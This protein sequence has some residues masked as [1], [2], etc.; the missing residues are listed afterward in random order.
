VPR[1]IAVLVV[2]ASSS[3][4]AAIIVDSHASGLMKRLVGAGAAEDPRTRAIRDAVPTMGLTFILLATSVIGVRCGISVAE[5]KR[6]NT[7][8]DLLLTAQSFR[9]ITNGKMWGILHATFPYVIAYTLPVFVVATVGGPIAL[10]SAAVWL[11]LP[12]IA[13]LLAA[14]SGIDMLRIPPDMDETRR[15]GAFWFENKQTSTYVDGWGSLSQEKDHRAFIAMAGLPGTG[16]STIA[17]GL[18]HV[19]GA[20]ILDKERV[21]TALFSEVV[22]DRTD[23][24]SDLAMAAIYHAAASIFRNNP[25]QSVI[26][27]GRTFL[28]SYEVRSLLKLARKVNQYP[29]IIECVCADEVARVR[30][31]KDQ[32][33]GTRPARNRPFDHY[34]RSK[35]AAEPLTLPRLTLDTGVVPLDRCI[36]R[37][38]A[39][40]QRTQQ[41]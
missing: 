8:D 5:E 24:Q 33:A 9:E 30:L 7:W 18:A 2:F 11:I 20:A 12:C 10:F 29:C 21:R 41:R 31:E 3:A 17:N 26:L 6:Q 16:K 36:E 35:D 1:W 4:F 15:G 27:D 34:L 22:L 40:V 28:R 39:Y 23:E 38:L 25:E 19:L 37:A 13:V 32:S 14:H